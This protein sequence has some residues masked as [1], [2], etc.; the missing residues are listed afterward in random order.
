MI[1][2]YLGYM[3]HNQLTLLAF[4]CGDNNKTKEKTKYDETQKENLC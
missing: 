1:S 3:L 4:S 2:K